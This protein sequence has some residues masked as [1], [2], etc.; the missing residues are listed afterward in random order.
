[1][2]R[3]IEMIKEYDIIRIVATLLVV[4]GHC[5]YYSIITM[6]G[7]INYTNIIQNYDLTNAKTY[8]ILCIL[9]RVIYSFHMPLFFSLSG[10]LFYL[11]LNSIKESSFKKFIHKKFYRLI[12][13]FFL[14]TLIYSVPLKY[15]SG[16]Y[17]E[18]NDVM[19]N[20][21]IGQ[22]FIQGNTHLW[23]LLTLFFIFVIALI[24]EKLLI[25]S[26]IKVLIIIAIYLVG[27][28]LE[29]YVLIYDVSIYLLWF[30]CGYY[31]EKRRI[32][33]NNYIDR[34]G[35]LFEIIITS[36]FFISFIIMNYYNF[37]KML[38]NSIKS[39]I[40]SIITA[41]LGCINIYI[42]SH[43][44]TKFSYLSENK[45]YKNILSNSFGIY[46]YSDPINYLI[47]YIIFRLTSVDMFVSEFG[48][49]LIFIIRLILTLVFSIII[50]EFFRKIRFK[51][52]Y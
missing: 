29:N 46:L 8:S 1:M 27:F 12:I 44:L 32:N 36:F 26:C 23:F 31:F 25:S 47:L 39:F 17:E 34:R 9:I 13:P 11:S 16:Y 49:V 19:R 48:A 24:L 45:F 42:Y 28:R 33:V 37:D 22:I 41:M 14:V 43:K 51:Y 3:K 35:Y 5:T 7:G 6:Y 10:S 21:I 2:S 50:S 30:Y 20:I 18:S 38:L 52:M 4:I 15:V 40:F